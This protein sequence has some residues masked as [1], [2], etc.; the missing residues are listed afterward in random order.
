M[1]DGLAHPHLGDWGGSARIV[2]VARDGAETSRT[3]GEI[4]ERAGRVAANL[5]ALGLEPGDGIA[6]MLDNCLEVFDLA[7]ACQRSGLYYTA[8]NRH[9]TFAEVAHILDDCGAKVFVVSARYRELAERLRTTHAPSHVFAAHGAVN[10]H[11]PF[12]DLLVDAPE[13]P[14]REGCELLYSSGTTGKPKGIVR[15]LPEPGDMVLTHRGAAQ[16]YTADGSGPGTTFLTASP[17]YHAAPLVGSL[18][19]ARIGATVVVLERFDPALFLETIERHRV[20]HIE[21][22]PTMFVRLLKLSEAERSGYDLRSVVAV[23]HAAAPCPV[24]VKARMIE[25]WGPIINE[26]YAGTEGFGST[27]IRAEEWLAHPGSVG[28]GRGLV[29][30][31]GDDGREVP[32]GESGAV[33]FAG[34]GDFTYRN[35]PAPAAAAVPNGWRTYGEIGHLDDDGYLYLTDRAS[36]M[37]VAGGVNIYPQEVEDVLIDHPAVADVAV[38]GIPDPDMGEQVK[39]VVQLMPGH[40]LDGALVADL[41]AHASERLA[42]FKCP[43][44]YDETD[45]L[46][47][48]PN[49]KLYKRRLRDQYS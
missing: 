10:G 18:V 14:A 37:I 27:M 22:V 25:W 38:F 21:V 3:L 35:A 24:S 48:D 2:V 29:H 1:T 28:H 39:A 19:H 40:R 32:A 44:T 41:D 46:P 30:I 26:Y 12:D 36:H 23:T 31:V 13:A 9:L 17:L 7:W 11:R 34:G 4:H 49:G 42:P 8:I 5:Y 15:P 33:Y 43:R 47:R 45:E 20:T 16:A 6:F